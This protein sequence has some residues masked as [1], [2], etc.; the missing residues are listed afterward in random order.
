MGLWTQKYKREAAF[1][2]ETELEVKLSL[3]LWNTTT[4][5]FRKANLQW[6]IGSWLVYYC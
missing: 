1:T 6:R 3:G 5:A 2:L 4:D